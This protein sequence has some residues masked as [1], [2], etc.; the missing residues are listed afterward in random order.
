MPMTI[1]VTRNVEGRVRGFLSSTMLEIASGVFAAPNLTPAVRDRIW[2]VLTKWE[3][4]TRD[5]GA[6]MTWPDAQAPGGQIVRTLGE[7]PLELHET[8]S[9]VL[10]RR[11]LSEAETS[12]LTIMLS[13][14]P[15]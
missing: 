11:P 12:S 6:V 14:P 8:P 9:V 13:D 3:V 1:V 2:A 15:F 7:P 4:G 10:T 5:D